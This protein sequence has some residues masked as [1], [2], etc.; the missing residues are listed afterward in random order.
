MTTG[1]RKDPQ[2]VRHALLRAASNVIACEGLSKMTVGS[3]ARAA[4]VTK[5]G[6]FHHFENKQALIEGM[7]DQMLE[8][9]DA[10]ID[11]KM[12]SDPERHGRFTRALLRGL[13]D[14]IDPD[15]EKALLAKTLCSAMAG[16][17]R[18]QRRWRDW[19]DARVQ[20]HAETD[21]NVACTIVRLATD[22]IWLSELHNDGTAPKVDPDVCDALLKMTKAPA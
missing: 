11:E 10:I 6:L 1:R 3:V 14:G 22:G 9:V 16:D 17:E 20:R 13:L 21:D 8:D 12:A 15:P 19:L 2:G 4:G 5:G 18:L 7:L